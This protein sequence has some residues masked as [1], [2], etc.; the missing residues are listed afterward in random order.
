MRLRKQDMGLHRAVYVKL[1]ILVALTTISSPIS[2]PL[3]HNLAYERSAEHAGAATSDLGYL[4]P[5]IIYV[6]VTFIFSYK[7]YKKIMIYGNKYTERPQ[8]QNLSLNKLIST[9]DDL[10]NGTN[11]SHQR[12]YIEREWLATYSYKGQKHKTTIF[13]PRIQ[14]I[15]VQYVSMYI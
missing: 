9:D 15:D 3:F 4:L 5:S 8:Y 12:H 1:P 6:T 7:E 2:S 10:H 11:G 14:S 13:S